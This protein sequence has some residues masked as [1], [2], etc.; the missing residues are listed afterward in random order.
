MGKDNEENKG[1]GAEEEVVKHPEH[2]DVIEPE[3][4]GEEQPKAAE[5][6]AK[7]EPDWKAEFHA[8]QLKLSRLEGET[9][10]L[11]A[12]KA[13]A[14]KAEEPDWEELLFTDPKAAVALIKKTIRDE[15]IGE[16]SQS[17]RKDQGEKEFWGDFYAKNADLK[18]DDD[19][20]KTTLQKNLGELADLPVAKAAER[21]A[22]LTRERIMRYTG[23]APKG[24]KKAVTEGAG[25]PTAGKKAPEPQAALTLSD[26]IKARRAKRLNKAS[27]A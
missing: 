22:E 4:K 9:N 1:A 20:V 18:E 19:L 14:K 24:G 17:Y 12:P 2:G 11:K 7:E 5:P 23:Q 26:I 6:K 10:A 16:V 27:A 15:V 3:G 8:L 21:L 13:P 25:Q